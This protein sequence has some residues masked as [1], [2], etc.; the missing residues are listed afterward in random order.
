MKLYP[1]QTASGTCV[2]GGVTLPRDRE[3]WRLSR[4]RVRDRRR[5]ARRPADRGLGS[6]ERRRGLSCERLSL[7]GSRDELDI[8]ASAATVGVTSVFALTSLEEVPYN[9]TIKINVGWLI[10]T[11][12]IHCAQRPHKVTSQIHRGSAQ[13]MI[14]VTPTPSLAYFAESYI[15][16]LHAMVANWGV[17]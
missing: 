9:D 7:G 2:T 6:R 14:F 11:V 3:R 4:E 15:R 8:S 13:N 12:L 5:L 1:P 10:K 16:I 17:I